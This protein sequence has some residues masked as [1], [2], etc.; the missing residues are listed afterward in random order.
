MKKKLDDLNR[1][2]RH[3]KN[4]NNGL[5]HKRSSLRRAIEEH[6]RQ[7]TIECRQGFIEHERAFGGAYRSY[8]IEG[9]SR[10]DVDTFFSRIRGELISLIN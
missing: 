10:K 4:K 5:I 1:K 6:T 2:I 8:R 7:P 3:S 9:R